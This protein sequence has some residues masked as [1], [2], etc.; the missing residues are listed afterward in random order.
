MARKG[1]AVKRFV[2]PEALLQ[3]NALAWLKVRGILAWRMALGPV[4]KAGGRVYAQN[5]LRGFPD[6]AGVCSRTQPGRMWAVEFKSTKGRLS[7]SQEE[8]LTKLRH[9]GC[10][11]RVVRYVGD[12]EAFFRELG[13]IQ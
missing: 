8:W 11:V 5:P 6:I 9:A 1:L 13:E 2:S 7:K 4:L 10:A 12:L 3:R